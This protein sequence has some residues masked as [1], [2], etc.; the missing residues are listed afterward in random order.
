MKFLNSY[1][2][3]FE[4]SQSKK[5]R[6]YIGYSV[7]LKWYNANKEKIAKL[8][9]VE[10]SELADEDTLM[11]QSYDLV[12]SVIN[13]QTGGNS[14]ID[15][16]S[17][18]GFES[19]KKIEN[20]LIHDILHNLFNVKYKDF[21]KSLSDIEFTESEIIEE[22]E[23]LA[24]EESFMKYM[25]ITYPKTDFINANINQL[26][27][28]LMM[29]IIKNDPERIQKILDKEVEPYLE[30]YGKK[31]PV[32]G[33]AFET[34]FDLFENKDADSSFKI[35]NSEDFKNYMIQLINVGEGISASNGDRAQYPNGEYY[36]L[37][38]WYDLD[39]DDKYRYINNY[40]DALA[41]DHDEE[42]ILLSIDDNNIDKWKFDYLVVDAGLNI[43]KNKPIGKG[44]E[45]IKKIYTN[46]LK[47]LIDLGFDENTVKNTKYSML[48]VYLNEINYDKEEIKV[49]YLNK[50]TNKRYRGWIKIENIPNY[51][52]AQ[53]KLEGKSEFREENYDNREELTAL[54]IR[55]KFIDIELA[56]VDDMNGWFDYLENLFGGGII[57]KIG[58]KK[59]IGIVKKEEEIENEDGDYESQNK[60]KIITSREFD[61]EISDFYNQ[62]ND[63]DY[64]P[65]DH[66]FIN[67][68]ENMKMPFNEI[69]KK[70]FYDTD[71]VSIMRRNFRLGDIIKNNLSIGNLIG[72]GVDTETIITKN[73]AHS[74]L[75]FKGSSDPEKSIS[76]EILTD[77]GKK[78]VELLNNFRGY[79]I[80]N[81]KEIKSEFKAGKAKF[82]EKDIQTFKNLN[83]DDLKQIEEFNPKDLEFSLNVFLYSRNATLSFSN[84]LEKLVKFF[85]KFEDVNKLNKLIQNSDDIEY[86]KNFVNL[87][88]S[89][90]TTKDYYDF[91]KL[92]NSISRKDI[93]RYKNT[94][95]KLTSI[96]SGYTS[97]YRSNLPSSFAPELKLDD[98]LWQEVRKFYEDNKSENPKVPLKNDLPGMKELA[99]KIVERYFPGLNF[100]DIE[101]KSFDIIHFIFNFTITP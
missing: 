15:S 24:I 6:Q 47:K 82:S 71:A 38:N 93:F 70:L 72:Y 61:E 76:K 95:K 17:I 73:R 94:I 51:L 19:F 66:E 1:T 45:D 53:L 26:A 101:I 32:K 2:K 90:K 88:G 75:D 3:F 18:P 40:F 62:H 41:K 74:Y 13:P 11:K 34:F 37:M 97:S 89:I 63:D 60:Y 46:V 99:S 23:C 57:Y 58:D 42:Y 92:I 78:L 86:L 22:I 28:Y 87:R 35:K 68:A 50:E 5:I 64:F 56:W 69:A 21:N 4:S 79:V 59:Y 65:H 52:E 81:F 91:K 12:N 29:A 9:N 48:K 83:I 96:L 8:L 67:V 80:K 54:P 27:S 98:A 36:G 77:N 7:V 33:T 10:P 49:D 44:K 14:G 20:N 85:D 43:F 39:N 30:V 100:T 84:K 31:Y 16:T 25:N 55:A